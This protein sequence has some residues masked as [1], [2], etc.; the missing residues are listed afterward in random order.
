MS[1]RLENHAALSRSICIEDIFVTL[2]GQSHYLSEWK[3]HL[4]KWSFSLVYWYNLI[5]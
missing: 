4:T 5:T 2:E 3:E 1:H